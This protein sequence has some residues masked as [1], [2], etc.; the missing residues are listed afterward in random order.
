MYRIKSDGHLSIMGEY[1]NSWGFCPAIWRALT[2]LY[3]PDGMP[4]GGSDDDRFEWVMQGRKSWIMYPDHCFKF[5]GAACDNGQMKEAERIC[6]LCT[7][8]Y[9][10]VKIE[11]VPKIANAFEEFAKIHSILPKGRLF[12]FSTMAKDLRRREN[13][14]E[15]DRGICWNG[16][17]LFDTFSAPIEG[18]RYNFDLD[19]KHE[20]L[21]FA[22]EPK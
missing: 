3:V 2:A 22:V 14:G 1:N 6:Y 19:S 5:M 7:L 9:V 20:W 15:G 11:D 10:A 13:W 4:I 8:D 18:R 21:D 12:H 17:S 16:T